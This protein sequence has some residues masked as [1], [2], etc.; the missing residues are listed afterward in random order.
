MFA[1]ISIGSLLRRVHAMSLW[2]MLK[3]YPMVSPYHD[4]HQNSAQEDILL[5][6]RPGPNLATALHFHMPEAVYG[7]WKKIDTRGWVW[8]TNRSIAPSE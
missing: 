6:G 1:H 3:F 5:Q 8:Q 7:W 4:N 2:F